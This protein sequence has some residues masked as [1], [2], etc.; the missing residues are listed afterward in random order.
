MVVDLKLTNN[1][2]VPDFL[3]Y[4]DDG[5]IGFSQFGTLQTKYMLARPSIQQ[6]PYLPTRETKFYDIINSALIF[7][8]WKLN[9]IIEEDERRQCVEEG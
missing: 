6:S 4:S 5:R 3:N 1:V 9:M 8:L 2:I 7:A